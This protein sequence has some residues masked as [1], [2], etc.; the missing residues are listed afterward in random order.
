MSQS[1]KKQI[2]NWLDNAWRICLLIIAI[3]AYFCA[4]FLFLAAHGLLG[5][6]FLFV[7]IG[8]TIPF[9]FKKSRE[10]KAKFHLSRLHVRICVQM[11]D[12][13][14]LGEDEIYMEDTKHACRNCGY[15]YIGYYCP[16]CGQDW[17]KDKIRWNSLFYDMLGEAIN[18]DGSII[19]TIYELVRRPG[20][21]LH[22]YIDGSHNRYSNPMKFVL[23]SGLI[24]AL[25]AFLFPSA[26]VFEFE[27]SGSFLQNIFEKFYNNI[28]VFQCIMAFV[29]EFL[30]LYWAF[31]STN[32]GRKL[33]KV[34]FY[35]IM[36]YLI[37]MDLLIRAMMCPL[38]Q[39]NY[40]W[41]YIRWLVVFCYQFYVLKDFFQLRFWSM[42]KRYILR[43]TI[44]FLFVGMCIGLFFFVDIA[45]ALFGNQ[46]SRKTT[47]AEN[48]QEIVQ[49]KEL[50]EILP[51]TTYVF[52][53]M[54]ENVFGTN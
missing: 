46:E 33:S 20:I 44:Y 15:E 13:K 50:K 26:S 16:S 51:M 38:I 17:R 14:I 18:C 31:K 34:E 54:T 42:C 11:W 23:F 45:D 39:C 29:V 2:F 8:L 3:G 52:T 35:V 25:M 10:R 41:N 47:N 43:Y 32:E 21:A 28:V 48:G 36:L 1:L 5:L 12:K 4:L 37:G 40:K 30:P 7:G 53:A 9:A 24:F 19:R 22:K 27:S 6:I 49:N